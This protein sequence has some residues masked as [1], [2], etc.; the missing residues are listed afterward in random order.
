[1]DK[2]FDIHYHETPLVLSHAVGK[3]VKVAALPNHPSDILCINHKQELWRVNSVNA[4]SQIICALQGLQ[5]SEKSIIQIQIS[6]CLTYAAITRINYDESSNHGFIINLQN[7]ETVFELKDFGYHSE[8]A[9]FPI[10]FFQRVGHCHFV[11]A[12]DWNTLDIINLEPRK[13]LTSR[14]DDEITE[15]HRENC[16]FTEWSG[17]LK[18]SPDGKRIATMG[19][20]WHPVGIVWNFSL[21]NWLTNKWEADFGR[22]KMQLGE[23]NGIWH[24]SFAW[25]DNE[26]IIIWGDPETEHGRDIPE[27][28]V[29]IYNAI[30]G[31]KLFYFDGPTMD[32]FEIDESYLFTGKVD[33]KGINVWNWETGKLISEYV[34]D[35]SILTYLPCSKTFIARNNKQQLLRL[36]W[37]AKC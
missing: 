27:N 35:H 34:T 28:N 26:R 17:E 18:I 4:N 12:T 20:M 15:S 2:N 30:T 23:V 37:A 3:I 6:P 21:D 8:H 36:Q 7:G 33:G 32:L 25:L 9:D 14:N 10:A 19:W 31:K 5:L 22:S 16:L 24:S 11:Y 29:V 13:C 1:M